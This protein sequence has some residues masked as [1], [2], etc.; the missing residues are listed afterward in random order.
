MASTTDRAD[1]IRRRI[2]AEAGVDLAPVYESDSLTKAGA[3]VGSAIAKANK[4]DTF[5]RPE[6]AYQTQRAGERMDLREFPDEDEF[7]RRGM[8]NAL[9]GSKKFTRGE[10]RRGYRKL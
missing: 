3:A 9:S 2:M 6:T 5:K 4:G 1:A 8:Q 10:I 7:R